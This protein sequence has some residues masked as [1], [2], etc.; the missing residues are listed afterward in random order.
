MRGKPDAR[1]TVATGN[2]PVGG[3]KRDNDGIMITRAEAAI[4]ANAATHD[5]NIRRRGERIV[6]F[7]G[8]D[9]WRGLAV[10]IDMARQAGWRIVEEETG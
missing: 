4:T 6:T 2:G 7:P 3:G 8:Q 9:P 1:R 5:T 10:W